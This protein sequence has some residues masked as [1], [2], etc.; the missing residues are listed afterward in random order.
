M[1]L[2]LRKIGN[3]YGVILPKNVITSEVLE[4]GEIVITLGGNRQNVITSG[5]KNRNVITL[6]KPNVI[7]SEDNHPNVITLKDST[8]PK[9]Q[10]YIR[11]P[12][13]FEKC[14]KHSGFKGT[15]GCK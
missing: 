4:A 3:S 5:D 1:K 8:T 13:S 12:F 11:P 15:C 7:T 2:K 14:P 6:D 10:T 9:E